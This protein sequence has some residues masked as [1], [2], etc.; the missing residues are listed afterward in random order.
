MSNDKVDVIVKYVGKSDFSDNVPAEM[1]LQ[2]LKV[3]ALKYFQLDPGSADKYVLQYDGADV[4]QNKHVGDFA[5]NPVTFT[6]MLAKEVNK[7]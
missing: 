1:V 7:G 3:H 4:N 5:V 6:L 2:A